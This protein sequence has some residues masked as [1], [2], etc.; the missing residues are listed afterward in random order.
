MRNIKLTFQ[1]D[2]SNYSGWQRQKNTSRTIQGIAEFAL[3]QIFKKKI[4]LIGSGRSDIGVHALGQVANFKTA[5]GLA[6][7]CLKQGL[8]SLLPADI[9]VTKA[10]FVAA[11]FHARFKA[12]SKIYRYIINQKHYSVFLRNFVYFLPQPLQISAMQRAAQH[13]L[14]EHDFRSFQ[15]AGSNIRAKAEKSSIRTIKRIKVYKVQ[16]FILQ[17]APF[18]KKATASKNANFIYIDIEANGFL[19]RMARNIIGTLIEIG[20]KRYPPERIRRIIALKNRRFS[21]PTAPARG[22]FLMRVKY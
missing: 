12:K 6:L 11:D 3:M 20:K 4:S 18:P 7:S 21:G 10:E 13:L 19:Y 22:L 9:K 1:Y 2:G 5:S 14:G 17:L 15:A 8:N 16:S